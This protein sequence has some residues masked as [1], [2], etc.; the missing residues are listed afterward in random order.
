MQLLISDANIIID[1]EAGGLVNQMFR[2]EYRFGVPNVLFE[3]EL[4]EQ[5]GHLVTLG[6]EVIDVQP[7]SV[8]YAETLGE[9]YR[10]TGVMDLLALALARQECCPLLSGDKALRQV[11]KK[12]GIDVRGTIWL[13]GEMLRDKIIAKKVAR[14]AYNRMKASDR[15]LPWAEVEKQLKAYG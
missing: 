13:V 3:Q 14:D 11:A 7:A 6:L 9:R 10:A 15:R 5:H 12:E 4:R 8:R 2:L 1:I